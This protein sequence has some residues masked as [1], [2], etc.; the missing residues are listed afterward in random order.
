MLNKGHLSVYGLL[1]DNKGDVSRGSIYSLN[2]EEGL[3]SVWAFAK[4]RKIWLS[5]CEL[6]GSFVRVR[7]YLLRLAGFFIW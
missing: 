5:G 1:I 2:T 3:R 7:Q 6:C 4:L